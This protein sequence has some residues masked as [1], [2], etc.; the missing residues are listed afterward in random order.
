MNKRLVAGLGTLTALALTTT[1]LAPATAGGGVSHPKG[2]GWEHINVTDTLPA[3]YVCNVDITLKLKGHVRF[4]VNG[5]VPPKDW[6]GPKAGDLMLTESPDATSVV[7]NTK[8]RKK[9]KVDMSGPLT[10]RVAKNDNDLNGKSVG[11]F[12]YFGRGVKG[13][14][15]A[16]GTQWFSVYNFRDPIKGETDIHRTRGTTVELCHALGAK[17]VEGKNPPPPQA[18]SGVANGLTH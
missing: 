5:K 14:I 3:G 13:L 17:A 8:N 6:K 12:L 18:Q 1:G 10:T 7:T 16:K 4:T 9:V 2:E 11:G 15:Y